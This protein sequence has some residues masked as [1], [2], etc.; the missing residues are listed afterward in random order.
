MV[1]AAMEEHLNQLLALRELSEQWLD[2]MGLANRDNIADI[3]K[4]VIENEERLD[5]LDD[6][7]HQTLEEIK[8]NYHQIAKLAWNMAELS[9]D[10][11]HEMEIEQVENN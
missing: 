6:I 11:A 7:L 8:E 2:C 5:R 10:T 1:G 3:A 9:A 4:K